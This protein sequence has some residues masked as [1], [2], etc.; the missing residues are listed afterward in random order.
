MAPK[1]L[2][3]EGKSDF[4]LIRNLLGHHN[5][6]CTEA[7]KPAR[8]NSD[9]ISIE[10]KDGINLLLDGLEV[11][12]LR[13]EL[14]QLGIV[15][16]ADQNP[17]SRWEQLKSRIL[18]AGAATLPDKFPADGLHFILN[19]ST[20][21]D[22]KVGI[23]MMPDNQEKGYLEHFASQMIPEADPLWPRV[24][25]CVAQIPQEQRRFSTVHTRKAE[26]HTWLAWQEAPGKPMGLALRSQYLDAQA[27]IAQ[28]FVAWATQ[29]F[30]P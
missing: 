25:N 12:L 14:Q 5:L 1:I 27:P 17:E 7:S 8:S 22:I 4:H 3:V 2:L 6:N 16:D 29:L 10:P 11:L 13:G 21:P 19:R 15:V 26:L 30:T 9:N 18:G 23:W 28:Q 20:Q 24:L